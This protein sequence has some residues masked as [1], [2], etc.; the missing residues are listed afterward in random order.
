[1]LERSLTNAFDRAQG[2]A[3]RKF[4][5]ARLRARLLHRVRTASP[6]PAGPAGRPTSDKLAP[7]P[8]LSAALGEN[9]LDFAIPESEEEFP[10]GA[11]SESEGSRKAPLQ[12][13]RKSSGQNRAN[14][15]GAGNRP[16]N[17]WKRRK[18]RV[19]SR[20]RKTRRRK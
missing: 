20:C 1:M 10:E 18:K 4:R 12:K 13:A 14:F 6:R 3:A 11:T 16:G 15:P 17:W 8:Y 2:K 5:W 7:S 19:G 9:L